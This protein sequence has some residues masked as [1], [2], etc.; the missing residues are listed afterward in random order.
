MLVNAQSLGAIDTGFR[1]IFF[2]NLSDPK[3]LELVRG[4][5][6]VVSSTSKQE[7]YNWLYR[8]GNVREWI[9]PRVLNRFKAYGYTVE[10]KKWEDSVELDRD[11][12]TD[13]KLGQYVPQI[14][15]MAGEMN[16]HYLRLVTALLEGGFAVTCYDGQFFFDTDHPVGDG[17]SAGVAS[18]TDTMVLSATA[19]KLAFENLPTLIDDRGDPLGIVYDTLIVHP[20][21]RF[22]VKKLLEA[23]LFI[24]RAGTSVDYNEVQGLIPNV[25][26]DPYIS[27][28]N[29]WFLIDSS[30]ALKPIVLQIRESP[31]WA[32][33]TDPDDS[34]VFQ[35]DKFL[36]GTKA[37][38]NAGYLLWQLAY[39]STGTVAEP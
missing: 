14:Q 38:H 11:D 24:K 12:I 1:T 39:G 30:K 4:A 13:D 2:S 21:K 22:V 27:D 10:N 7:Q 28:S 32:G 34:F 16:N 8:L 25:I 3:T 23:E 33:V 19:L 18:N 15:T 31:Q 26:Y 29:K 20:S 35:T 6:Q 37:R 17:A 36:F 5:V 9:G